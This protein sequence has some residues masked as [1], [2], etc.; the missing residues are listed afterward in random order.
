MLTLQSDLLLAGSIVVH[1]F[2]QDARGLY[3]LDS[4]WKSGNNMT[5][6]EPAFETTQTLQTIAAD[7]SFS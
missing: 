4:L 1:V 5:K 2:S 3:D 7:T 6:V